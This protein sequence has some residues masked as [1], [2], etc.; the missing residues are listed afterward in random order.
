MDFSSSWEFSRKTGGHDVFK[1][2]YFLIFFK[3][4][5]WPAKKKRFHFLR[6]YCWETVSYSIRGLPRK[7]VGTCFSKMFINVFGIVCQM[8][9]S[10]PAA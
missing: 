4:H 1:K 7:I 3:G 9:T 10:L 5:T 2:L 8:K 6:K